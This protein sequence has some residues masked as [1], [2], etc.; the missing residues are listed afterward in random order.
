M[1]RA[2]ATPAVAALLAGPTV[3]AFFSGGYFDPPR[4]I[5]AIVAWALVLLAAVLSPRPLPASWPGRAALGGLALI[6]AW[7]AASLAW[8]PLRSATMESL[9]RL[10]LYLGVLVAA[11]ALLRDRRSVSAVEPALAGGSL[12]VIGYGLLGRLLPDHVALDASQRAGGRLEQ[13]L[14]YWNAEGA[15]A[16]MGLVLCARIAGDG[17]RPAAMRAAAAAGA[18]PLGLGVYLT[19]SRGAMAAA[20]VGLLVLLAAAPGRAQLRSAALALGGGVLAAAAAAPLRGFA[21]L[22]GSASD[23]ASEGF[24]MLAVLAALVLAA[25]L[26]QLRWAGREAA[27]RLTT[28]RLGVAPRLPALAALAVAVAVAG[29]VVGGLRERGDDGNRLAQRE[30]ASRFGSVDSRR[31][32]YWRVGAETFADH[33]I[34]GLGAGGFR[35]AWL[36]ERPVDEG[37]LDVHSLPLEMASDLGLVGLAAFLLF[38]G[39]GALAARDALRRR[40]AVAAGLTAAATVWLLHSTIDWDWQMPAVTVP[41]LIMLGALIGAGEP[42]PAARPQREAIG[43]SRSISAAARAERRGSDSR[44]AR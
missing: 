26:L 40:P 16:A 42:P 41:A 24:L 31:Y 9:T 4:L 3:M 13:P 32:D 2:V 35:V 23:R 30:G 19:L 21:A 1:P 37:A 18:A 7:T 36:R 22:D 11:A 27:G 34:A 25:G 28:E 15:L 17:S 12:L 5:G 39:G 44:V 33:P 10:M 43:F 38:A 6:C 8:A 14:T 20:V 29:L